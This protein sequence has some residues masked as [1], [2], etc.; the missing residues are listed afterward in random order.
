M[1]FFKHL[2]VVLAATAPGFVAAQ[3]VPAISAAHPRLML[4]A[5]TLATL[6]ASAAANSVQWQ[7][8]ESY[9][10]SFIGGTVNL[11]KQSAYP[12]AP[13]IGG[14]YQGDA[15]WS[16][17]LA[18]GLCYQTLKASNP[19]A[20]AS[21][22]DKAKQILLAMSTSGAD[23]QNPATDAG[24]GIR[25]YGVA[26]AIGYDWVYDRLGAADK[27]QIYTTANA[28]VSSFETSS[29]EY[30]HPQSNYFA[31]YFHAKAAIALA[32]YGDNPS[33]AAQWSDWYSNQFGQRV[34]PYYQ[35]HLA[36]GGWPEGFGNYGPLATLQMS[37]PILEAK[38]AT[39]IDLVHAATPFAYPVESADYM[40]HFTW[41]SR[42]YIDDRDTN[43]SSGNAVNPPGTA[44]GGM[45]MQAAGSL[46]AWNA[47]HANVLQ[48]YANEVN[49]ATAGFNSGD[50]W[51]QFLLWNA[52]GPTTPVSTLPLSYLAKGLGAVSARSDWGNGAAWM[53][54]RAGPYINN[55]DQGEENFDQGSIALVRGKT[56]LLLN[57]TGWMVHE[58]NGTAG[59]TSVYNDNYGSPCTSSV[60]TGNRQIYNVFYVRNMNGSAPAECFGQAAYTAENNGVRTGVTAYEDTT[61]YVYTLATHLEDMYRKFSGGTAV[62][63]WSREIVYVRPYQFV[64]YDRTAKGNAAY[65]QYLAFHFAG[66][67]TAAAAPAGTK[68]LDVNYNGTFAGAMSVV[69]PTGA[70]TTT[71]AMYPGSATTKAWQVQVRAPNSNASQQWVTVFDLSP[72]PAAVAAASKVNVTSGAVTGVLLTAASG[73]NVVLA[74]TGVAGTPIAGGISYTV[75]TATTRHVITELAPNSGYTISASVSGG[76]QTIKVLVGGPTQ[77]TANG[78]LNF[79]TSAEAAI[80]PVDTLFGNGFDN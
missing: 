10:D 61:N 48:Q 37:L 2:L 35:K 49:A 36:G 38:T 76:V 55:P 74:S 75:P 21:Y 65:D 70:T 71:T 15:Y 47:P 46:R 1:R 52:N 7:Q 79:S 78:T 45:F 77:T 59:E 56:P 31:G 41:P 13:H 19:T 68:R 25:F 30:N 42:D 6:R 69:G 23:G 63:S 64:V 20:A 60:Y 17:V 33:A 9:C 8:L 32:T 34:R 80:V 14:G 39:G 27:A 18:E 4:D 28:W 3:S 72:T 12:N 58:P 66:S 22:G 73:N 54:F 26:M 40:M 5:P 50:R 53:S 67:P 57:A 11:P 29:F 24:Y 51:A 43:R 44:Q 62:S 16:A